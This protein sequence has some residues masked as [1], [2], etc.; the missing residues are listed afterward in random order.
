MMRAINNFLYRRK[1]P[2]KLWVPDPSRITVDLLHCTLC[3][4]KV[5]GIVGNSAAI[6]SLG[7]TEDAKRA[8]RGFLEWY[9]QGVSAL[10]DERKLYDFTIAV[11]GW[12]KWMRS[13]RGQITLD[14][15]NV[16]VAG[17]TSE[18]IEKLLGEPFARSTRGE[19]V[20]FY[21]YDHGEVEYAFDEDDGTL[22]TIEFAY[23]SE[24]SV[25]KVRRY[26]GIDKELPEALAQRKLA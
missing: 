5:G 7:P 21:E 25:T 26:Y 19:L 1:D 22:S 17:L 24:L 3:G 2:T 20:L 6:E 8:A 23:E 9:S 10:I 16:E 15:Q 13:Y 11:Q 12:G 14:G 18:A 4:S